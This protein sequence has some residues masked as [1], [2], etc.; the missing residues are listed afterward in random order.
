MRK[1]LLLVTA[2][3]QAGAADKRE[4]TQTPIAAE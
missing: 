1:R 3:G 2:I 4:T